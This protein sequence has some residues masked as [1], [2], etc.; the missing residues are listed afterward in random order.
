MRNGKNL[1][2]I[3]FKLKLWKYGDFRE[4]SMKKKRCKYVIM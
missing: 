1:E 2:K 4:R 3:L